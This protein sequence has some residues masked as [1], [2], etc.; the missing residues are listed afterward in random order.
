[1]Y[2][3]CIS[4]IYVYSF[5]EAQATL[6]R[7]RKQV[8]MSREV[9]HTTSGRVTERGAGLYCKSETGMSIIQIDLQGKTSPPLR[10]L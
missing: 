8:T 6:L 10:S 2:N 9:T 3:I 1:M 5:Y 4:I 7:R